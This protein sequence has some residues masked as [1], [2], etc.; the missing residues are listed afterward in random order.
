MTKTQIKE[1]WEELNVISVREIP[2]DEIRELLKKAYTENEF[3]IELDGE[4]Y[5]FINADIIDGIHQEEIE[6][7]TKDCYDI[8]F[9]KLSWLEIDWEKTAKNVRDSDGY[10]NHF[11]TYDGYEWEVYI[12]EELYYYFRTN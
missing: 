2:K 3:Y 8:D 7:I 1:V 6:E 9:D 11:A 4:E 10:G 5:R 12:D